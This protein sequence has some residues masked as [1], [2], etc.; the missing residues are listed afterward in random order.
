MKSKCFLFFLVTLLTT[1]IRASSEYLQI[2][3]NINNYILLGNYVKAENKINV[4][5]QTKNNSNTQKIFLYKTLGDIYKSK[6]DLEEAYK[7]WIISNKLRSKLY[8]KRDYHLAW[9]Y[10]L[11]S[12][13]HYEK[14][15]IPLT[16]IY[17]DSCIQL[18]QNL[19]VAQ[20]KEIE[21]FKI[22]NILGQS[23]KQSYSNLNSDEKIK[24][25]E[26]I[27]NYYKL[28]EKFILKNSIN[29]ICLANT[30]HLIANSYFDNIHEFYLKKDKKGADPYFKNALK[31]YMKSIHI[32]DSLN[33]KM[34]SGKA[35][36]YYL[37]GMLYTCFGKEIIPDYHVEASYYFDQSL[38]SFGV[39]IHQ[40]NLDYLISLSRKESILQCIRY[41]TEFEF[42]NINSKNHNLKIQ[43]IERLNKI[44]IKIWQLLYL[45][46]K[47]NN[48]NLLLATYNLIPYKERIEIELLKRKFGEN[49]SIDKIFEANQFL[50]YYDLT[51]FKQIK[52][53][54][55]VINRKDIQ[56]KLTS[57][58]IFLDFISSQYDKNFVIEIRKENVK[59]IAI[60]K[61]VYFKKDS[62]KK[63]ISEINFPNFTEHASD[64]YKLIFN[65]I[66]VSSLNKIIICP[67]GQINEIPFEALLYSK[68][69]VQTKDFRKLD[70]LINHVQID[71][72]LAPRYL[73]LPQKGIEFKATIFCPSYN[74]SN[75][76]ELPFSE[77]FANDITK[78]NGVIVFKGPKVTKQKFLSIKTPILHLSGHGMID[79]KNT[80]FSQL[81]LTKS[82][83]ST[84]DVYKWKKSPEFV[85]INTCNSSNGKTM[86][87]DGVDGIIR[88]FHSNNT[89]VSI[90]NLWEVDDQISNQL[91]YSFYSN[92]TENQSVNRAFRSTKMNYIKKAAS[93]NLAAPYYWAG[94]KIIGEMNV[95]TSSS[96]M[97]YFIIYGLIILLSGYISIILLKRKF[98]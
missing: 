74:N 54:N 37:L 17:A 90:S 65:V 62:L 57:K 61:T 94:H 34:S 96:K 85:V 55:A 49:W 10:A 41:Y 82:S 81:L 4:Q 76:S 12:N 26:N 71:Y 63:S 95:K 72:T 19:T 13:Y 7:F 3:S 38:K 87:G 78:I 44:A 88:A 92:I 14:I 27:R 29:P 91:F 32:W 5:L 79:I 28:S 50:K 70:Y 42:Q 20:Q 73:L 80:I 51:K 36:S 43:K 21:I 2:N 93:S 18:I 22:W 66:D 84:E 89:K 45:D 15:E 86:I 46:C 53:L 69:N 98:R 75:F 56:I 1:F 11:I 23:I 83:V 68:K 97:I 9:N 33:N 59:L 16:K 8:K 35:T 52:S 24:K 30:Y 47:S 48:T 31:Y 67:D 25:Y 64:I 60:D 77:K 58:E 39:D 6:G 40:Q